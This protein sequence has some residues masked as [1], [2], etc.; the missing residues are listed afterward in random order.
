MNRNSFALLQ[1]SPSFAQDNFSC[2]LSL[3]LSLSFSLIDFPCLSIFN[4]NR[5][6]F[7]GVQRA[8]YRYR[9]S[10]TSGEANG[11]A[12]PVGRRGSVDQFHRDG[13]QG[14]DIADCNSS[15]CS[16]LPLPHPF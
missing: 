15:F 3:S 4:H 7:A 10:D 6:S 9:E 11:A 1:L 13:L 14:Y 12:S 5:C 2:S 16:H 8:G